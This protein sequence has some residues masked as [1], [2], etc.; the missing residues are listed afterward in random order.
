MSIT[1]THAIPTAT[2]AL[3]LVFVG[4]I[5]PISDKEVAVHSDRHAIVPLFNAWAVWWNSES[6]LGWSEP[7][8]DARIFA[9]AVESFA[10]SEPQPMTLIVAPLMWSGQSPVLAYNVYLA[11]TILLNGAFA[12]GIIRKITGA[13]LLSCF[14][15]TLFATLPILM[16]HL[17][18]AQLVAVW[19]ILWSW[20]AMIRLASQPSW[21]T[22][23][24]LGVAIAATFFCSVHHGLFNGLVLVVIA[25]VLLWPSR[26]RQAKRWWPS[27]RVV[28]FG[29][30]A[31]AIAASLAGP[32]ILPMR[33]ILR[34]QR[35]ARSSELAE[36]LSAR[37]THYTTRPNSIWEARPNPQAEGQMLSPG[38]AVTVLAA[39]G[40]FG[41]LSYERRWTAML[42]AIA[43]VSATLSFGA[44]LRVGDWSIWSSLVNCVP[45]LAQVRSVHRFAFLAHLALAFLA[46]SGLRYLLDT[47]RMTN[48]VRRNLWHGLAVILVVA[49]IF[50]Q[51]P[52]RKLR[53][54]APM[55]SG[56]EPW[57]AAVREQTP[58]GATVLCLPMGTG[59][60]V[61]QFLPEVQWMLFA[62][63]HKQRI[64]NGYSGFFP[65]H[66][67]NLRSQ[68][69]DSEIDIDL[70]TELYSDNVRVL[71][72]DRSAQT[73]P[74]L[75]GA[76]VSVPIHE[77]TDG[78][79]VY[80][81]ERI[82]RME[83]GNR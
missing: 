29:L 72:I 35:F 78:I 74:A 49:S 37:P 61:S 22:S 31:A 24:K 57:I 56:D 42:A 28:L 11:A 58:T 10:F 1:R 71:A 36:K 41:G 15:A 5:V 13:T 26:S 19:P 40:L 16:S 4:W 81:I 54:A 65:R 48:R 12:A 70:L 55:L 60:R 69:D 7:Y 3:L 38:L 80:R 21:A 73:P 67:M 59:K 25:P 32:M 34:E 76:F 75:P 53:A 23:V 43:A 9:P 6:L 30:A 46:C 20:Y 44:N 45:G 47:E 52:N 14:A 66:Y 64:A 39:F 82:E 18:V 51:F 79:S 68:L 2:A 62:T 17:H 77:D 50:E 27:C 8:W 63:M 33:A 83:K